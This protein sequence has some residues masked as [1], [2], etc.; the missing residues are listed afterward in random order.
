MEYNEKEFQCYANKLALRVWVIIVAI[1]TVAYAI[2]VAGGKK[3]MPFYMMFLFLAWVPIILDVILLKVRGMH[4]KVFKE[5]LIIGY[6]IF[7]AFVMFTAETAITFSYAFPVAGMLILY[8]N[9]KLLLRTATANILVIIGVFA[10]T[11]ITGQQTARTMPDFEV[12]L[13]CTILCYMSY[14]LAQNYL[15]KAENSLL[16]S[17]EG[18][19]QKVVSTVEKVKVAS[20]AVVDGVTV[21]RELAEENKES[22]D[23]VA[24]SMSQLASNN[25][26]LQDRT[27]SSLEMTQTINAQ[28]ENTAALIQ[29]MVGLMQQ[30]VAKAKLSSSQLEEVVESTKEMSD[31]STEVEKILQDFRAEFDLVKTETGTIEEI[32]SQTNLL[33]LN[34]SIE[35]ARAGEVGKG[36]AVVADE[37][38]NLSTG[39]KDSSISIM[40]ALTH[41]E[42]TSN[43]MMASIAKTI[44]LIGVTLDHVMDVNESVTGITEDSI[45]LGDNIQ[46]V[47]TAMQEVEKSNRSM[48]ENMQQVT[49]V[50]NIMT[51]SIIGAENDT[52]VM[53]SKYAETSLNVE[54]IED[55]VGKLIEELGEGGFMGIQDLEAGMYFTI[56]AKGSGTKEESKGRITGMTEDVIE[57]DVF[58]KFVVSPK[59]E[60]SLRVIVEN[61]VY[62]W[63]DI[64]ITADSDRKVRLYVEGNP[65]VFNRRKHPRMLLN[66]SCTL[67]MHGQEMQG[68]MVNISA[69]GFAITSHAEALK[70]AKGENVLLKI[71]NFE[72]TSAKEIEGRIIR[73]SD[74]SGQYIV[75]CRMLEERDDILDYVEKHV[76]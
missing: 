48:V 54:T 46:V 31:L 21:V 64:L 24:E 45:K 3:G 59:V 29:E 39:T 44:E 73:V 32:S 60:Y 13:A 53:R 42:E 51:D 27:N 6:G 7:F 19:L 33:A 63:K 47:D 67:K 57:A 41:L 20:N 61:E 58:E 56:I 43:K 71:S 10:K 16:Y 40:E 68:E 5:V 2:E 9:K 17:V 34:A 52:R 36:F 35:A 22:A 49:E 75:G 15:M 26:I 11:M 50:M 12:Q 55:V 38:R 69:G 8:K 14:V 25:E 1:L 65:K 30:S 72:L 4:T 18:N 74:N 62:L 76:G 66:K 70:D 23:G 37:I 28:V